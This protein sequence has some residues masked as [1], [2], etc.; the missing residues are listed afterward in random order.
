VPLASYGIDGVTAFLIRVVERLEHYH[1]RK[2]RP[3]QLDALRSIFS[4]MFG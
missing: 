1:R 4:N 2:I 3:R